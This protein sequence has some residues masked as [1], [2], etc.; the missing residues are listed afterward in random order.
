MSNI[1]GLTDTE[2]KNE[3]DAAQDET[4]VLSLQMDY[5]SLAFYA[6]YLNEQELFDHKVDKIE[7]REERLATIKEFK[8]STSDS[9]VSL[10]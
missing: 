8:Q 6:F 5:Y 7:K 2:I 4:H 1:N 3:D 10:R 9:I